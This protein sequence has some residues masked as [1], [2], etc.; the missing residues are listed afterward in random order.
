MTDNNRNGYG[1]QYFRNRDKYMGGF[2]NDMAHGHGTY[3]ASETGK[4]LMAVWSCN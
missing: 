3:Y 1:I 4:R 2:L